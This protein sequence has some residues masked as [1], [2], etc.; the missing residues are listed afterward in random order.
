MTD[1]RWLQFMQHD[2]APNG[3]LLWE[4]QEFSS[5]DLLSNQECI[6]WMFPNHETSGSGG[7]TPLLLPI[8]CEVIRISKTIRGEV[9]RNF[10]LLLGHWG[11]LRTGSILHRG[12]TFDEGAR[13]WLTPIDPNHLHITRVL[14]FLS[15]T[16]FSGL[17][18]ALYD[19]LYGELLQAVLTDI[20]ALP[21][22]RRA[23]SL[24]PLT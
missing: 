10:D 17:A 4:I 11:I 9:A 18:T 12:A 7:D 23:L 8:H 13:L 14:T 19:F 6:E 22:W 16:G 15:L 3:F 21:D 2:L 20:V 5:I 1:D 24:P